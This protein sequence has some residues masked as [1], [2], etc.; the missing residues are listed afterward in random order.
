MLKNGET[1]TGYRR[2]G[3]QRFQ[4]PKPSFLGKENRV[5]SN[6]T[7]QKNR[8]LRVLSKRKTDRTTPHGARRNTLRDV[9]RRRALVA[10]K[11]NRKSGGAQ[12]REAS[13][14][15]GALGSE[16]R[17]AK[18][19]VRRGK[20]GSQKGG[21]GVKKGG[22]QPGEISYTRKSASIRH[23]AKPPLNMRRRIGK[24]KAKNQAKENIYDF[25]L[26]RRADPAEPL[27]KLRGSS[28]SRGNQ[29]IYEKQDSSIF[30]QKREW[31]Y[32]SMKNVFKV[33]SGK[34]GGKGVLID[35]SNFQTMNLTSGLR[36]QEAKKRLQRPSI[37]KL[38]KFNHLKQNGSKTSLTYQCPNSIK[39][40]Q[41]MYS[42]IFSKKEIESFVRANS[43]KAHENENFVCKPKPAKKNNLDE[44]F[45]NLE[46][47]SDKPLK[48]R[49]GSILLNQ[50]KRK[51]KSGKDERTS[52]GRKRNR[53]F[54]SLE[55]MVIESKIKKRD[56]VNIFETIYKEKARPDSRKNNR[57]RKSSRLSINSQGAGWASRNH[58][59]NS[60]KTKVCKWRKVE[61][62]L[63]LKTEG[64]EIENS[65]YCKENLKKMGQNQEFNVPQ[66]PSQPKT[67]NQPSTLDI[68]TQNSKCR[69]NGQKMNQMEVKISSF[70]KQSRNNSEKNILQPHAIK[71]ETPEIQKIHQNKYL[72][73]QVKE[74]KNLQNDSREEG[75]FGDCLKDSVSEDKENKLQ[76]EEDDSEL[77]KMSQHS[78]L[79]LEIESPVKSVLRDSQLEVVKIPKTF[80]F[81]DNFK[82][83]LSHHI[84][85]I[86]DHLHG[87]ELKCL[88][89]DDYFKKKQKQVDAK[90]REV[91]VDWLIEV[92]NRYK[93]RDETIFLAVRLIDK[94]LSLRP[95]EYDRF[96]LLGTASLMIAAKYEEIYPPKVKDFVY[97]CANA[98]TRSDVLE[99]EAR[100]LTLMDFDLVF[101]TSVQFFGFFQ[102]LH[103]FEETVRNL[104][105]YILYGSLVSHNFARTNPRLLAYSSVIMANKAFKNYEGIKAFKECVEGDFDESEVNL[106][107][108]QIYNMLLDN[109][110]SELSAL[111]TRFSS[112]K[113]GN[114]AQIQQRVH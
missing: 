21:R 28:I 109:K 105:M 48:P 94:Y 52:Q 19:A 95:I 101:P 91:L 90:M 113:Y 88:V 73:L 75:V 37:S 6:I 99:M 81:R 83:I 14:F 3:S 40:K 106:C 77:L 68:K 57:R 110:K 41:K 58:E 74:S 92:H 61:N 44:F 64:L 87:R 102:K 18:E 39:D 29:S 33:D 4:V 79:V 2:R 112:E 85:K 71:E 22:R 111:R 108:F 26:S 27:A 20:A 55:K 98:Y 65:L 59:G 25:P 100:I 66:I 1:K 67:Q 36:S 45:R 5:P 31:N 17:V 82:D 42:K 96:Q 12:N 80:Q 51:G 10:S 9:D 69:A 47:R 107:I 60:G 34:A 72:Q 76:I 89:A 53:T 56:V 50:N 63:K 11:N 78:D 7:E 103:K 35:A 86:T 24:I 104:S 30:G 43:G 62:S 32:Q 8:S 38:E 13:F 46:L 84:A 16:R 70:F 15:E 93:M 114:I 97:I 23:E 49:M 54:E